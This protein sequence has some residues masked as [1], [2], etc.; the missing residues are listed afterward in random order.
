MSFWN[1][2]SSYTPA[3]Y[4]RYNL[5][6]GLVGEPLPHCPLD[7]HEAWRNWITR[8]WFAW[9]SEGYPFWGNMHHTQSW[10]EYRHLDNIRFVH[11]GDL[12]SNLAGEIRGMADFL[13]IPTAG[14]AIAGILPNLSLE[15]MRENEARLNPR[16]Q[17]MFRDGAQTFF[18]KGS[19]G[20]WKEVLSEEEV[21]LYDQTASRV[22]SPE[23]RRWLE[24]GRM[25]NRVDSV[26]AETASTIG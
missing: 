11:Y 12:L 22:L 4:D 24:Q 19:N 9:E 10:W 17:Q 7:L 18:F 13:E 25:A 16:F 23:C 3:A 26:G 1:H 8:G 21:A 20:R 14:E 5:T 15:S 6:P 2:Y